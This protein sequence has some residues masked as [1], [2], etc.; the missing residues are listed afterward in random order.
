MRLQTTCRSKTQLA[1]CF[2]GVSVF[3]INTVKPWGRQIW[4]SKQQFMIHTTCLQW[5]LRIMQL[6]PDP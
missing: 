6:R 5:E 4:S 3:G 1:D 2:F